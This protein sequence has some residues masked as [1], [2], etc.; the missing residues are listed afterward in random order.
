MHLQTFNHFLYHWECERCQNIVKT[1][2]SRNS[3]KTSM[4]DRFNS[5]FD[6][7]Q[8]HR[9]FLIWIRKCVSYRMSQSENGK[10]GRRHPVI[11]GKRTTQ[12]SREVLSAARALSDWLEHGFAGPKC[13]GKTTA[14]TSQGRNCPSLLSPVRNRGRHPWGG[15]IIAHTYGIVLYN[16]YRIPSTRYIR[17]RY[18]GSSVPIVLRDPNRHRIIRRGGQL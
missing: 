2:R 4:K 17:S 14:E 7:E 15:G 5:D 8:F 11:R 9:I 18:P 13:T 16:G 12:F 6:F 3:S 10:N 1:Q